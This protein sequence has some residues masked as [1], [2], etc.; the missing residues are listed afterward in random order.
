MS[1]FSPRNFI[2]PLTN[3]VNL[4]AIILVILLFAV[5]R[6]SAGRMN[7]ELRNTAKKQE[8]E[9]RQV[10]PVATIAQNVS[11]D[12][13]ALVPGP[14]LAPPP[15]KAPAGSDLKSEIEALSKGAPKT[16][17]K[18]AAAGGSGAGGNADDGSLG[19]VEKQ[20]GIR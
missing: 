18:S 2:S 15:V 19:E 12:V 3:T 13:A 17:S 9:T 20:L 16:G 1:I 6:F 10:L 14:A 7:A 5:F 4:V 8:A 11:P